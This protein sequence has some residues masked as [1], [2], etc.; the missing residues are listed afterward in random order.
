ML[1]ELGIENELVIPV[2]NVTKNKENDYRQYYTNEARNDV[3]EAFKK[4]LE[5]FNYSF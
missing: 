4:E 3:A 1:N 5:H 2:V